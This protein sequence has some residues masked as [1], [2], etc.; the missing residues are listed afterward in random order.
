MKKTIIDAV[1]SI[2]GLVCTLA[3]IGVAGGVERDLCSIPKAIVVSIIIFAILG[4]D[5]LIAKWRNVL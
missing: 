4:I 5:I 3:I 1:Q 2:I